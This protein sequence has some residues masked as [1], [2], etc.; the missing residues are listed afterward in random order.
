MAARLPEIT[1]KVRCMPLHTQGK[2]EIKKDKAW[3]AKKPLK[4]P[5]VYSYVF[6]KLRQ[7]WSPEQISG[8]LKLDYPD[9]SDRQIGVETIYRFIYKSGNKKLRLWDYLRRKQ[10]RRRKKGGRKAQRVRIPGRV[11]IHLRPRAVDNRKEAGHWEGDSIEAP[12]RITYR[13][14]KSFQHYKDAGNKKNQC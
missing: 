6:D 7:D 3:K 1:L 8:R 5:W 12:K 4:N 11:S 9:N 13:V 14:R 10:A 2:A